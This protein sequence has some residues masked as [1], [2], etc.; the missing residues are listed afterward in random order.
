MR[1]NDL[2]SLIMLS[3][4]DAR[5]G[6]CHPYFYDAPLHNTAGDFVPSL[7]MAELTEGLAGRKASF[8]GHDSCDKWSAVNKIVAAAGMPKDWGICKHCGGDAIDPEIKEV[9][10]AW[11][12]TPPPAGEGWQLWET[13]SEGSP[14]TPVFKTPEEL[15]RYC[16]D[17]K[18]SS[19][20]DQTETYE[21]WLKFI[22]GPG[23]ALSGIMHNGNMDSGVA[24]AA[25]DK[26]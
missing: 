3:G 23:W 9:Y 14:Q 18:V 7:D 20:G 5:R 4:E 17:N 13:T 2:V 16:T 8:M 26:S 25:K 6:K 21:T 15:A 11:T 24:F 22:R 19:F 12:E 10:E 1:L